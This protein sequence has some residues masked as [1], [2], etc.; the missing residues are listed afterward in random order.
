MVA[1][2]NKHMMI[3]Q[4]QV[5]TETEIPVDVD[6]LLSQLGDQAIELKSYDAILL[7]HFKDIDEEGRV[8]IE[9]LMAE[10]VAADEGKV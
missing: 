3:D 5:T 6:Q 1:P 9:E 4:D 7:E 8:F 10:N 2:L